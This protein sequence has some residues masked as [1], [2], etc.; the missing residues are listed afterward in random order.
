MS[1]RHPKLK[2]IVAAL[3]L[4]VTYSL[5]LS[6]QTAEPVP[7]LPVP[8]VADVAPDLTSEP[9]LLD[10]LTAAAGERG[11]GGECTWGW[12]AD[13][14]IGLIERRSSSPLYFFIATNRAGLR[15]AASLRCLWI[16]P[17]S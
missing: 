11:K 12:L 8:D 17:P 7:E 5:P 4:I 16:V 14:F 1:I 3:G 13:L 9:E 15:R 6:A 10:R 2:G